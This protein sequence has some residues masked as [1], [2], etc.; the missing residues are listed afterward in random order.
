MVNVK[1]VEA[2]YQTCHN[3]NNVMQDLQT[4]IRNMLV[5]LQTKQQET[6]M[7]EI[8]SS[9]LVM[10]AIQK[11]STIEA[12]IA[13]LTPL[14][15][16][17]AVELAYQESQLAIAMENLALMQQRLALSQALLQK[18]TIFLESTQAKLSNSSLSFGMYLDELNARLGNA[19]NALNEYLNTNFDKESKEYIT[20]KNQQYEYTKMQYKIGNASLKDVNDAYIQKLE[21]NKQTFIASSV[22]S[23]VGIKISKY[24]LPEFNSN[25]SVKIDI[26][27]F[28]KSRIAHNIIANKALKNELDS[29]ASLKS[30]FNERQIEQINLGITPDGYTWHHD[31]NPPPGNLQLVESRVHN[32]IRHHGGYSLWADRS[33]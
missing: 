11:V 29:N 10:E 5:S 12:T 3:A 6:N 4:S 17:S 30:S 13:Y 33:T 23:E 24:N 16:E 32:K 21:A 14:L 28:N 15:P 7:E 26:K 20:Q 18:T 8:K 1:S 27:D 22:A 19:G 9:G 2:L 25:F 31:G